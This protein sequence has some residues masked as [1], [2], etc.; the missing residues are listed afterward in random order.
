MTLSDVFARVVY[1]ATTTFVWG[2]PTT[3]TAEERV[4]AYTELYDMV[5]KRHKSFVSDVLPLLRAAG[6][7]GSCIRDTQNAT[8]QLKV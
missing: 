4:Q 8:V 5:E 2:C 6:K 1:L 3:E 7:E